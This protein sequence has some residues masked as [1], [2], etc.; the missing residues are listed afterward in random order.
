M[1]FVHQILA[2]INFDVYFVGYLYYSSDKC[3]EDGTYWNTKLYFA[4]CFVWVSSLVTTLGK[5]HRLRLFKKRV[6]RE[7][8][9]PKRGEVIGEWEDYVTRNCIICSSH[10]II[11]VIK[12]Q[13]IGWAG[14]VANV[15]PRRGA[16][17]VLMVSRRGKS[18]LKRY[19]HIW[20]DN[21]KVN[22]QEVG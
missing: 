12:S 17:R 7:I 9:E 1:Y 13:R 3:M 6:L 16:C 22:L 4:C 14:H 19:R 15:G 2:V 5:E 8:F 10:H 21:K 11:S 20:E 18:P